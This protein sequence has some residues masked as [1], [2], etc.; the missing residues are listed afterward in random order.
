[1]NNEIRAAIEANKE[2]IAVVESADWTSGKPGAYR[3]A[4]EI[5]LSIPGV[6]EAIATEWLH[7][8]D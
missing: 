4:M 3:Q 2:L 8:E 7:E 1:M 6:D 5:L